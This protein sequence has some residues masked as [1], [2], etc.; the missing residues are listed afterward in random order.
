MGADR[1]DQGGPVVVGN[2]LFGADEAVTRWCAAR[3]P[4]FQISA[5]AKAIGVTRGS[6]ML[7][8]FVFERFN[9]VHVEASIA[10]EPGARWATRPVLRGI[11]GYPFNTLGCKAITSVISA[12]NL[13]S[14]KTALQFGFEGE[15]TLRFAAHDGGDLVVMKLYRENCR[16]LED[17]KRKRER[18]AGARSL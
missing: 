10:A 17:G 16:W 2:L 8:G 11:C 12:S 6:K 4:G 5:G 15:A 3:I 18:A 13:L 9:G 7:A 1:V 14:I